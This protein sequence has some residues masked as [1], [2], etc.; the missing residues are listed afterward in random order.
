MNPYPR[1]WTCPSPS[2][3]QLKRCLLSAWKYQP[4]L[5]S[6]IFPFFLF[7]RFLSF[8]QNSPWQ[9]RHL[10]G[11]PTPPCLGSGV[12]VGG[13]RGP[14]CTLPPVHGMHPGPTSPWGAQ[15]G[16]GTGPPK[17]LSCSPAQ[18][19]CSQSQI[20]REETCRLL[21]EKR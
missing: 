19:T 7:L 11:G 14:I 13:Q 12:P 20:P 8:L 5:V 10:Q 17:G 16:W 2:I 15:G 1:T 9:P 18:E 21:W 6:S 4:V 3:P